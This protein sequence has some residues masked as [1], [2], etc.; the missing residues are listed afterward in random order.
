MVKALQQLQL[1]C[2]AAA[3]IFS[4]QFLAGDVQ[5]R[6][7]CPGFSWENHPNHGNIYK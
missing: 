1:Y 4:L 5:S 7:C 6:E 3:F 2:R